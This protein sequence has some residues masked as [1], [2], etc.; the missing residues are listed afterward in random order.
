MRTLTLFLL[1][2]VTLALAAPAQA[3]V[4]HQ[5]ASSTL[6]LKPLDGSVPHGGATLAQGRLTYTSD[7]ITPYT[8]LSGISVQYQIVDGPAWATV[9]VSP[10]QDVIPVHDTPHGVTWTATRMLQIQIILSADAPAGAVGQIVVEAVTQPSGFAGDTVSRAALA[11]VV[12]PDD[13]C[14]HPESVMAAEGEATDVT[15][16]SA[17][18]APAPATATPIAAVGLGAL[19]AVGIALYARKRKA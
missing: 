7:A 5:T 18:S 12:A 1:A 16:Q 13:A 6:E 9:I 11:V 14:H 2:L 4:V 19:A 10:S 17:A 3:Q 15:L 8:S